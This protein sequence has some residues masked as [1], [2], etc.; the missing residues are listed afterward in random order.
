MP[1]DSFPVFESGEIVV[2]RVVRIGVEMVIRDRNLKS[3]SHLTGGLWVE[4]WQGVLNVA[5][6][7]L[8]A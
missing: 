4:P 3:M 1:F 8:D 5:G 6:K 2:D 7:R